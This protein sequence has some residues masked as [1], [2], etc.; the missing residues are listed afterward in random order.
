M[1]AS[2]AERVRQAVSSTVTSLIAVPYGEELWRC[3]RAKKS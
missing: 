2:M 1:A 3:A